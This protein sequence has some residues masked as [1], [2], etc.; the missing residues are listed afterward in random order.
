MVT[1]DYRY[2]AH[3]VY[4]YSLFVHFDSKVKVRI[5]LSAGCYLICRLKFVIF[6][7]L[8]TP[9]AK[10][11]VAM[12]I[13]PLPEVNSCSSSM[14]IHMLNQD[15]P[16]VELSYPNQFHHFTEPVGS[17]WK[18]VQL[19]LLQQ[20]E[21]QHRARYLTEGSRGPIKN[22]TFDG[23]PTIQVNMRVW[24]NLIWRANYRK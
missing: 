14:C 8:Y 4:F 24:T 20:P 11:E 19:H 21:K 6:L 17:T 9:D 3:D 15:S 2:A 5:I 1:D 23:Y 16:L 7:G 13:D 10:E 12:N 18:D 22:R